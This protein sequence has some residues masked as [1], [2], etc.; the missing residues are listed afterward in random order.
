MESSVTSRVLWAEKGGL[1]LSDKRGHIQWRTSLEPV[2]MGK[3]NIMKYLDNSGGK[4]LIYLNR[5]DI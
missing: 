4:P 2:G 5:N 1:E 3:C